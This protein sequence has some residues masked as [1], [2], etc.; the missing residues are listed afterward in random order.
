MRTIKIG[1]E[2]IVPYKENLEDTIKDIWIK[3]ND[4]DFVEITLITEDGYIIYDDQLN[5]L[6]VLEEDSNV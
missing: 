5:D 1:T 4:K 6:V 3:F 2:I